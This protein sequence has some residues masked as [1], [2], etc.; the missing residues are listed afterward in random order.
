MPVHKAAYHHP[1]GLLVIL[2]K[3]FLSK[4]YSFLVVRVCVRVCPVQEVDIH[5]HCLSYWRYKTTGSSGSVIS[6]PYISP[7]FSYKLLIGPVI[8]RISF[9]GAQ[10]LLT[11]DRDQRG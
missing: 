5:V 11:R 6:C 10:K 8:T 1:I 9:Y 3:L 2:V 7:V 4:V